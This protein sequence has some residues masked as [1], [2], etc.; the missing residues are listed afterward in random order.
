MDNRTIDYYNQNIDKFVSD[1]KDVEFTSTQ[2]LFLS[3]LKEGSSILDLG[4]GSGRDTKCFLSKGY[5]VCASDGSIEICKAASAYLGIEVKHQLFNELDD[6]EIYDGIWACSSILHLDRKM[7]VD[8]FRR[9][10]KALKE[11]GILYTSFKYS[12]YEGMRNGRYFID[13]TTESFHVFMKDLNGFVIEKEYVSSDV[14]PG[15][16]EEKWLNLIMRK[17]NE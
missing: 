16:S 13:F 7:L 12:E 10:N 2:D 15:R 9:I 5:K 17:V 1:T 14:R 6:Y 3:Y 4:C 8:A 11:N